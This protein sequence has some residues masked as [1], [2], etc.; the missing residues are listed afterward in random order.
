MVAG[1]VVLSGLHF[2]YPTPDPT[3]EAAQ[4]LRGVL[5]A[6]NPSPLRVPHEWS[7]ADTPCRPGNCLPL[8]PKT[9]WG[10]FGGLGRE[11]EAL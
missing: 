9:T 8:K 10:F 5:R 2:A 11:N 6:L 1:H 7:H 3:S 4:E